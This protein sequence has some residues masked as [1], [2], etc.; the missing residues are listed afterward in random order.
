MPKTKFKGAVTLFRPEGSKSHHARLKFPDG[1]TDS[2][3]TGRAGKVPAMRKGVGVWGKIARERGIIPPRGQ[4]K[5]KP[6]KANGYGRDKPRGHALG[7]YGKLADMKVDERGLARLRALTLVM[8]AL[9]EL[10]PSDV[11]WVFA[12]A[13]LLR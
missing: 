10:P 6:G 13:Q 4:A 11:A 5:K 9:Q 12:T 2:V 8:P 1:H 3:D 7:L